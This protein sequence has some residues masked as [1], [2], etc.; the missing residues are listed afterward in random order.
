M[1]KEEIFKQLKPILADRLSIS[2]ETIT[3]EST[4]EDMGADSLDRVDTIMAIEKS[5]DIA[6]KDEEM[7]KLKC[8]KDIVEY[9]QSNTNILNNHAA[10]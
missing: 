8:V 4:F 2:E 1:N 5:F 6:M 10:K 9:I 3:E 7:E